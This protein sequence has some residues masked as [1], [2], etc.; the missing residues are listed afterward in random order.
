MTSEELLEWWHT[1]TPT[2]VDDNDQ[3]HAAW[4][5][6]IVSI[7]PKPLAEGE[8]PSVREIQ[9]EHREIFKVTYILLFHS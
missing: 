3:R 1:K 2:E 9:E 6:F 7:C 4:R 5:E 8:W